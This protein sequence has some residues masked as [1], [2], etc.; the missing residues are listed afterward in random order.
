M[1]HHRSRLS[2]FATL[3]AS[4][5]SSRTAELIHVEAQT[6]DLAYSGFV[7][8][9]RQQQDGLLFSNPIMQLDSEKFPTLLLPFLAHGFNAVRSCSSCGELFVLTAGSQKGPEQCSC[10]RQQEQRD[11]KRRWRAEV[12]A[13]ISSRVCPICGAEFTPRRSDAK[14]CS[15]KCRTKLS[16]AGK[17]QG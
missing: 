17:A 12:T 8:G 4:A 5:A 2:T 14:T 7:T 16:R 6:L 15:A 3:M 9:I 11:R 10:C 1:S 13:P